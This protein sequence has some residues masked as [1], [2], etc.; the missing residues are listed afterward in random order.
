MSSFKT[1]KDAS[2]SVVHDNAPGSEVVGDREW[3]R[4]NPPRRDCNIAWPSR[5]SRRERTYQTQEPE[6]VDLPVRRLKPIRT[7]LLSLSTGPCPPA[8][9]CP[10]PSHGVPELELKEACLAQQD[11][12]ISL[13]SFSWRLELQVRRVA[14]SVGRGESSQYFLAEWTSLTMLASP[15]ERPPKC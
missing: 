13:S 14:L 6:P 11:G 3:R 15:N 10:R 5:S 7:V 2:K 12:A 8:R 4:S 9:W 1:G